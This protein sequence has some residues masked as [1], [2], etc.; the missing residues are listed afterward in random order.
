MN[1]L[2]ELFTE[3]GTHVR[4]FSKHVVYQERLCKY[5]KLVRVKSERED[6]PDRANSGH[7]TPVELQMAKKFDT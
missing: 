4:N 5:S 6:R 3:D 1:Q 2:V 7:R